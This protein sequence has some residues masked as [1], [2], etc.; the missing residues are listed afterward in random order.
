VTTFLLG[1]ISSVTAS[2]VCNVLPGSVDCGTGTIDQIHGNGVVNI[3]GTTV[4]GAT[5]VNG[6][7]SAKN[8][9]FSS[10]EINGSATI[11]NSIINNQ[12]S[13]KGTLAASSTKFN[14]GLTIYSS[15]TK[16]TKSRVIGDLHLSHIDQN[17]Q[18]I[19][20]YDLSEVTGNIIF[21]DGQGI[22]FISGKSK[23]GG[24][25]IG[26]KISFQ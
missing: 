23:I 1:S 17:K 6:M 15:L 19:Y 4:T 8:A 18:V 14:N 11:F 25:V 13:I 12:S 20:L 26:G 3:D 10:L 16:F 7:L 2:Q 9:N 21:D 22:V 24:K 5:M